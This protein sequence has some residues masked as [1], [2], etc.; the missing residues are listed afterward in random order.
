MREQD[1]LQIVTD[2]MERS[3]RSND[4]EWR[5]GLGDTRFELLLLFTYNINQGF[6]VSRARDHSKNPKHSTSTLG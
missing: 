2:D 3:L 6:Y 4:G 5:W 1:Q